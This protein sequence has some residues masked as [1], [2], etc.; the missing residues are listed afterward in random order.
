MES[1]GRDVELSLN[2]GHPVIAVALGKKRNLNIMKL[3]VIA[4]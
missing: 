2:E 4:T 1:G 3:S